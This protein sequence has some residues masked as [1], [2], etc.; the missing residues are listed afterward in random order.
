MLALTRRT[1]HHPIF[2]A[3][4]RLVVADPPGTW[5]ADEIRFLLWPDTPDH[6]PIRQREEGGPQLLGSC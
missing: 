6:L 4:N 1:H 3:D 2:H 5:A